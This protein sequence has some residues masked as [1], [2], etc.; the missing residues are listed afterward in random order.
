MKGKPKLEK[1]NQFL[2]LRLIATIIV[3]IVLRGLLVFAGYHKAFSRRVELT[4]PVSSWFRG[5]SLYS[6]YSLSV[7]T[8]T[9]LC[10]FF[11]CNFF[12]S[13]SLCSYSFLDLQITVLFLF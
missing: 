2:S 4:S 5:I 11:P 10:H 6:P 13:E 7:H 8:I 12:D 3:S 1:Q 9:S